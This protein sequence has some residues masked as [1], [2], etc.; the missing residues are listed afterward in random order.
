MLWER[1]IRLT[2]VVRHRVIRERAGRPEPM[3]GALLADKKTKGRV[4]TESRSAGGWS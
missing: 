1:G 4:F 3:K 2:L